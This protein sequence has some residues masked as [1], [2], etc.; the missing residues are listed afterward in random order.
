MGR[1]I[2]E[3]QLALGLYVIL[4]YLLAVARLLIFMGDYRPPVSISGRLATGRLLLPGY[5]KAFLPSIFAVLA[6]YAMP[7]LF[8]QLAVPPIGAFSA[9]I[10]VVV[11]LLLTLK[12]TLREWHYTG[13]H[14]LLPGAL[15]NAL[16]KKLSNAGKR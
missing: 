3:P 13:H 6:G 16:Y 12:P 8:A 4:L 1:R 2:L 9:S 5:D 14:R 7:M 10:F 11:L 15:A